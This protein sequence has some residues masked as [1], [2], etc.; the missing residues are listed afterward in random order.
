MSRRKFTSEFKFKVVLEVLSERYTIQELGRKYE[1]HPTQITNWKS[2]FLKNGQA[3]FDRPVKDSK[4]EAQ[5][6]EDRYLKV[7]GQQKMEIDFLKKAS[8]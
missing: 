7:I 2:Q 5:E 8:Q 6:L 3:V 4:T 1:I